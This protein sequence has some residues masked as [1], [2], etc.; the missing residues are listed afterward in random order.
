MGAGRHDVEC[1]L[2]QPQDDANEG[3]STEWTRSSGIATRESRRWDI[4]HRICPA[5]K[6]MGSEGFVPPKVIADDGT[7]IQI[8][9]LEKLYRIFERC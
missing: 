6:S 3:D 7:V 1:T 4:E 2:E 9:S 5:L 8:A